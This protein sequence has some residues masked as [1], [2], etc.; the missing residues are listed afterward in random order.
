VIQSKWRFRGG[1]ASLQEIMVVIKGYGN[2]KSD[3]DIFVIS[4]R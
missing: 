1:S 2:G 4:H 3:I